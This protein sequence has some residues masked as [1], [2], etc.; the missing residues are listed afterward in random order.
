MFETDLQ[1]GLLQ[2]GLSADGFA[3][4]A[5]C[6]QSR[7]SRAFRQVAPFSGPETIEFSK[8]LAELRGINS[9]CEPLVLD[10]RR[11]EMVRVLLDHRRNGCRWVA[12]PVQMRPEQPETE[13]T[14][15]NPR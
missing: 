15:P 11:L 8:L 13:E 7:L 6:S 1:N 3:M 2:L 12:T 4:L 9:D 14:Q 10:F 5:G